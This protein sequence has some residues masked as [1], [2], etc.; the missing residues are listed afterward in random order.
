MSGVVFCKATTLSS[1]QFA[2]HIAIVYVAA[3]LAARAAKL[4]FFCPVHLC[5]LRCSQLA[6]SMM[7]GLT[8]LAIIVPIWMLADHYR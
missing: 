2:R 4:A 7:A 5:M 1:E 3:M 8:F 6:V